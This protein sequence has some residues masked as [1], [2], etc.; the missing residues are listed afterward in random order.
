[1]HDI[2]NHPHYICFF[3]VPPPR[4]SQNPLSKGICE[5]ALEKG[6]HLTR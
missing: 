3:A 1:M 2:C 6:G 4:P 5:F